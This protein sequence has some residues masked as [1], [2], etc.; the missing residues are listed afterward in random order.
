[1]PGLR[2]VLL[3]LC[4]LT[5]SLWSQSVFQSEDISYG[6]IKYSDLAKENLKCVNKYIYRLSKSGKVKDSSLEY[7][8]ARDT[9]SN[10]FT[11]L[12]RKSNNARESRYRRND[13]M[14]YSSSGKLAR[15]AISISWR[16]RRRYLEQHRDRKEIVFTYYPNDSVLSRMERHLWSI[17]EVRARHDTAIIFLADSTFLRYEYDAHWRKSRIFEQRMGGCCPTHYMSDEFIYDSMGNLVK[18]IEYTDIIYQGPV[19]STTAYHHQKGYRSVVTDS[20][21][22]QVIRIRYNRSDTSQPAITWTR[23]TRERTH[24]VPP[25]I[26]YDTSIGIYDS[27]GNILSARACFD[28]KC[29]IRS[30]RN[31]YE[32][33]K[34]V[35]V[36]AKEGKLTYELYYSYS[37]A[38]F[39]LERK[40]M[41]KGKVVELDR[42]YYQ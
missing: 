41:R 16:T 38:G 9:A 2:I 36:L 8:F 23:I 37:T 34:L 1:M 35:K 13:T 33:G 28:G 12:L 6:K 39:L 27:M 4:G 17:M 14:W 25:R 10:I 19:E 21:R 24:S 22:D 26:Y 29:R 5:R 32:N 20:S 30:Y 31:F 11:G 40:K 18:H 15:T 42:Y 3:M 7:A